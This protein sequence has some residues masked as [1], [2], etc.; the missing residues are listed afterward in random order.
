LEKRWLLRKL[1]APVSDPNWKHWQLDD[2][3]KLVAK[4]DEASLHYWERGT[5]LPLV[6]DYSHLPHWPKRMAQW[7]A[8]TFLLAYLDRIRPKIG[9]HYQPSS[10]PIHI[11]QEI[12]EKLSLLDQ[13]GVQHP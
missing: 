1:L 7:V 11:N 10:V 12:V 9:L 3:A 8:H 13:R 5:P 6:E 2:W 4:S